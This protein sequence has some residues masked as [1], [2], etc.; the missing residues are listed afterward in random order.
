VEN[1]PTVGCN[2]RKTNKQ[3]FW[4]KLFIGALLTGY[5]MKIKGARGVN[6][7]RLPYIYRRCGGTYLHIQG[8]ALKEVPFSSFCLVL[9]MEAKPYFRKSVDNKLQTRRNIHFSWTVWP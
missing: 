6:L 4:K 5:F 9:K 8:Q 7:C 1:T 2:D 3:T